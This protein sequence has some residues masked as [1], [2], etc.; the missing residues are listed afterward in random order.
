[1]A[2]QLGCKSR[3]KAGPLYNGRTRSRYVPCPPRFAEKNCGLV[4]GNAAEDPGKSSRPERKSND[5]PGSPCPRPN[6]SARRR[7]KGLADTRAGASTE[8]SSDFVF[9][10]SGQRDGLRPPAGRRHQRRTGNSEIKRG[11]LS[12]FG[13][14]LR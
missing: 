5:S 6:G 2:L 10:R 11:G 3:K 12:A 8:P 1:M 13:E 4:R 9:G 14:L 7:R